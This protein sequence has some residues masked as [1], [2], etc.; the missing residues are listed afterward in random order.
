VVA[1]VEEES[2]SGGAEESGD[3][4]AYAEDGG[5]E[6]AGDG[7]KKG[8]GGDADEEAPP[9]FVHELVDTMG[10][11]EEAGVRDELVVGGEVGDV[12][13]DDDVEAAPEDEVDA[14]FGAAAGGL[15][16]FWLVAGGGH[17]EVVGGK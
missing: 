3:G 4:D 5:D 9:H 12:G 17:G 6:F 7:G 11:G 10:E 15:F 8:E 14:A 16:G 13:G 1:E 2:G